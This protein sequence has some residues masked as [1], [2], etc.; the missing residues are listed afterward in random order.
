MH[1]EIRSR[2]VPVDESL[3]EFVQKRL[4][5]AVGRFSDSLFFAR[6]RFEDVNGPKGGVDTICRI[7][8]EGPRLGT[9]VV[10]GRGQDAGEAA[11]GALERLSQV[12]RRWVDKVKTRFWRGPARLAWEG[13]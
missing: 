8:L 3:R 4:A 11:A 6:V 7:S 10:E 12:V 13:L 5:F 1:V 9:V 2:R